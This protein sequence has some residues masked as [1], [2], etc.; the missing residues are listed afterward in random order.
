MNIEINVTKLE[1]GATRTPELP[2][3]LCTNGIMAIG[4]SKSTRKRFFMLLYNTLDYKLLIFTEANKERCVRKKCSPAGSLLDGLW[5][6][7]AA[8]FPSISSTFSS[9][10]FLFL[11]PETLNDRVG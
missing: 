7:P 5:T 4:S 1:T 11:E 8:I 10:F 6:P 2:T 9:I 3:L